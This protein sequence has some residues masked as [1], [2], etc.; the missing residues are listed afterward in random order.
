MQ[1]LGK[2]KRCYP[3]EEKEEEK[4]NSNKKI[5]TILED[6]KIDVKIK[7]AVPLNAWAV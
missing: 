2:Y 4:M 6:V 5:A 1:D 7:L 3:K